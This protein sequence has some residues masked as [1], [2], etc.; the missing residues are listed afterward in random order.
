MLHNLRRIPFFSDLPD[1]ELRAISEQLRRERYL[2]GHVIF[3]EGEEG[4]ALYLIESGQVQVVTGLP[5]EEKILA[6]L[7]PGNFFGELALLLNEPRSA[8]VRVVIDAEVWVLRKQDLELL[9]EDHPIIALQMS[10]ELSRR[11]VETS[12]TPTRLEEY[13]LVAVVG[14]NASKLALSL[15]RQ[16]GQ[17]VVLYDMGGLTLTRADE[18]AMHAVGIMVLD[19]QSTAYLR[20]G[21]LAETLGYLAEKFD[22]V[23]MSVSPQKRQITSKAMEL[24]D[25][26]VLLD[27]APEP[28][29][30]QASRGRLWPSATDPTSID[31][32]A[33]R[34]S[35]RTVG[36]ALSSG[37][38][39]GIAHI[40][41]LRV[42]EEA[43]VPIDMIA[44]TSAGSLFGSLYAAGLGFGQLTTFALGMKKKW[45]L[46]GGLWDLQIPPKSGL[47]WGRKATRYFEQVLGNRTFAD[48]KVP[49]YIVAAD[50]LSG[51]QVVFEEGPV[52]PAI[53]ASISMVGMAAPA[54]VG[55][56]F[57]I[58]GGAVNPLPASVLAQRGANIIIGCSVIAGFE[59]EARLKGIASGRD[60]NIFDV[61]SRH[62]AIMER[63]I[64]KTRMGP[65]NVLIRPRIE[66]FTTMDY[67]KVQDLIR[68][69]EEAAREALPKIQALIAPRTPS[70]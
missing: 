2:K 63:E 28:W 57:L 16:T 53:R 29:I 65:V 67:D 66:T 4:D 30:V 52:A 10:R 58:D 49:M 70:R 38:A 9:L 64:I 59:E 46:R 18:K 36:L 6:Y 56:R 21:G 23:L 35:R 48:L 54:Q 39:R 62:M 3:S 40:G 15:A 25:V 41:V 11:L 45:Q 61:I 24:S 27:C 55:E 51:E 68:V 31:R 5:P 7:G 20:K 43:G 69:G 1:T 44:G 8:T 26:G 47:F 14:S 22:W 32:L 60:L 19:R 33:R 13:N 50:L 34:I 17:R 42:L 37:G 12:H